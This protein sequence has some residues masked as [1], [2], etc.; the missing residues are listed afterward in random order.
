[1][2]RGF[3]TGERIL[4]M[5]RGTS[6]RGLC[7]IHPRRLERGSDVASITHNRCRHMRGCFALCRC[8]I[9]AAGTRARDLAVINSRRFEQ[10]SRVAQLAGR[11]ARDMSCG[12]TF[13]I[14]PVVTRNA[15]ACDL[16]MINFC[17]RFE[18]GCRVAR[19]A[20]SR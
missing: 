16:G 20:R 14:D 13:S 6:T 9:V 4:A 19:F 18:R 10:C 7:V 1:M 8:S 5:A 3:P 17:R 15:R 12:L 2:C 11:R